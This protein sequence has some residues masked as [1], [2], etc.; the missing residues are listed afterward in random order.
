MSNGDSFLTSLNIQMTETSRSPFTHHPS[1]MAIP[2]TT[3]VF[4]FCLML[5]S[6]LQHNCITD[7]SELNHSTI[8][9][10]CHCASFSAEKKHVIEKPFYFFVSDKNDRP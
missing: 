5:P 4:A 7:N 2:V 6:Q 8:Q 3:W 10:I 1:S 9:L